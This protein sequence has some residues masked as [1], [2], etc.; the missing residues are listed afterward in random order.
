MKRCLAAAGTLAWL[1]LAAPH[2]ACAQAKQLD[3]IATRIDKALKP[4]KPRMVAFVDFRVPDAAATSQQAGHFFAWT[5]SLLVQGKEKKQLHVAEHLAFDSDLG[6]IH[7]S[8]DA[9]VP[10]PSLSA[11]APQIGPDVLVIGTIQKDGDAYLVRATP[12][13]VAENKLRSPIEERIPTNDFLESLLSPWPPKLDQPMVKAG[14]GTS[15]MPSCISCPDPSYSDIAR[16]NRIQGTNVFEVVIGTDGVVKA[17]RPVK[18]LGYGLDQQAFYTI[19]NWKFKPAA[20][21]DGTPV[22]VMTPIEVSFRLY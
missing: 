9:L 2:L 22:P 15:T 12:L 17:I 20:R 13:V 19:R 21:A 16:K 11:A 8:P 1:C 14:K 7:I 5:L 3:E 18:L 10:G 4:L 6:K